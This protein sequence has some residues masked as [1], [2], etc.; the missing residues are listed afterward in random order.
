ML[1]SLV[2]KKRESDASEHNESDKKKRLKLHEDGVAGFQFFREALDNPASFLQKSDR[3][4]GEPQTFG[5]ESE[6]VYR[7]C[8]SELLA[9]I[10]KAVDEK[11]GGKIGS[12]LVEIRGSAGIGKSAFLA[13]TMAIELQGGM[14]NFSLL[15]APKTLEDKAYPISEVRCSVWING[16]LKMDGAKYRLEKTQIELDS[17]WNKLDIIY[18]DG[19]SMPIKMDDFSGLILVAAPPSVD[20]KG[21][22]KSLP[23]NYVIF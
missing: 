2:R 22:R 8:Y 20:T 1:S 5:L 13:L 3:K 19:C 16:E 18:M 17:L 6:A 4:E 23:G 11:W 15:H 21:L 7:E 9:D 10:G 14:K 12:Y